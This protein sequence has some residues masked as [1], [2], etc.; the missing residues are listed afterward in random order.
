MGTVGDPEDQWWGQMA[1]RYFLVGCVIGQVSKQS[2]CECQAM[3]GTVARRQS[4]KAHT[5]GPNLSPESGRLV[6]LG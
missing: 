6:G 5:L 2:F 4:S 3:V 1:G